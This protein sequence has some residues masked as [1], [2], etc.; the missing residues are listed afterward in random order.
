MKTFLTLFKYERR[1]LFPSLRLKR[2][3][4][5]IG[6]FLSLAVSLLVIAVFLLLVAAVADSYVTIKLDKVSDPTAR[7]LELL[8]ALYTIAILGLAAMCLEK[9]RTSLVSFAGKKIFLRIP[10]GS[11][12]MFLSKF[13]ALLLWNYVTAFCLI[14]PINL[15]FYHVLQPGMAFITNSLLVLLLLPMASF[16]I[17]TLLLLPYIKVIDFLKTRYFLTF[18]IFSAALVGAFFLYSKMLSVLQGLYETGSVK[19]LFSK[20]FVSVLQTLDKVT[21]P[22]NSLARIALGQDIQNSLMISGGV[23]VLALLIMLIV[24]KKLYKVTLYKDENRKVKRGRRHVIARRPLFALMRKEFITV[25]REPKHLFSYFAIA[26]TMPFMVYCCYTL[27]E[28]LIINAIGLTFEL[29][30]AM[31]V[32]LVFSILTNTFCATNITRDGLSALKAKIFP[33]KPLRILLSKVLFCNIVSSLSIIASVIVLALLADLS[34]VNAIIVGA[35]GLV[36]SLSQIFIA[37]RMDLNHARVTRGPAEAAKASN[38]TIAKTITVGMFFAI[39]IG[40]LS[41]FISVFAGAELPEFLL[42]I[43]VHEYYTYVVPSVIAL[44]Y[45][46]LSCLYYSLNIERAFEKLVR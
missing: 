31:I 4:D 11:G 26:I 42:G 41:L 21:Y 14:L 29:A 2:R 3:P 15:I 25:F 16:L 43:Y 20:K 30:L 40:F 28:T 38:R 27:F 19:F 24:T 18:V 6:G 12:T 44:I 13:A 1:S 8:N 9:M 10:V 45:F 32:V 46:T 7:S 17:A 39:I 37:T 22:A 23:A 36:F 5:I 35:I 34:V 33:I